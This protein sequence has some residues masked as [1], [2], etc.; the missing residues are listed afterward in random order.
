MAHSLRAGTPQVNHEVPKTILDGIAGPVAGARPLAVLQ[1][2]G[3]K[4]LS[5]EDADALQAMAASFRFLK[6]VMEPGGAASLAAVLKHRPL[7]ADRNV[8]LVASGG[9]VDPAVFEKALK[10]EL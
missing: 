3:A 7:F 1:R 6:L 2:H 8:V 10:V 4:A 5:V 9:N